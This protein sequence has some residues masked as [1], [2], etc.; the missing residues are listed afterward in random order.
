[1][2]DVYWKHPGTVWGL[3]ALDT[4]QQE[5]RKGCENPNAVGF[6]RVFQNH[7]SPRRL[8]A[9]FRTLRVLPRQINSRRSMKLV[10]VR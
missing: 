6:A 4:L 7:R 9:G 2:W 5:C 8:P 3:G 10:H 1:M